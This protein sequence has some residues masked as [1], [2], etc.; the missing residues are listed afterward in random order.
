M[1]GPTL[2]FPALGLKVGVCLRVWVLALGSSGLG[3]LF[4]QQKGLKTKL[5]H[6][7]SSRVKVYSRIWV[8]CTNIQKLATPFRIWV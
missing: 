3:V 1:L 2:V 4:Q 5:A 8:C 6:G 7:R